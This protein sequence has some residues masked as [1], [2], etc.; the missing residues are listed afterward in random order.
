MI[1]VLVG[2]FLLALAL[3]VAGGAGSAIAAVA[4]LLGHEGTS[5][6]TESSIVIIAGIT[7]TVASLY[8]IFWLFT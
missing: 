4:F 7:I 6:V 3:L 8:G 5:S 1:L 2:K